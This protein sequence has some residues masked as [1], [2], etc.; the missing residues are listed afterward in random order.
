MA[1][2]FDGTNDNIGNENGVGGIDV[3]AFTLSVACRP[4][5]GN[6][7]MI[8]VGTT[9][10]T[11]GTSRFF[12]VADFPGVSGFRLRFNY[13]FSSAIGRWEYQTDLTLNVWRN[14]VV[15]YDRSSTTNNPR[16]WVDGSEVTFTEVVAPSGTVATGQDSCRF[17][18]DEN[19]TSDYEGDIAEA[20]F[21]DRI[22]TDD[23]AV[24][25]S[26][27]FS[28]L[29]FMRG[30]Q[31]HWDMIRN[32]NDRIAGANLTSTGSTIA[33]HL[34]MIYPTSPELVP[35]V[36][37]AAGGFIPYPNPRYALTGG[38]QPMSGGV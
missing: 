34:N 31:H 26:K 18:E 23:E 13:R 35:F 9:Q 32:L 25:L 22:V 7:G 19:A 24:A 16:L 33:V 6:G 21:W 27:G 37:A 15:T 5:D 29:F 4:A 3:N 36:A 12:V 17:G 11:S 14:F 10:F 30:L 2:N 38:M 8:W 28:P 20:G 1:R